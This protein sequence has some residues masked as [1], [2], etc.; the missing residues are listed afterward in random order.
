M[1][2][3]FDVFYE[4]LY[5]CEE[6]PE[7]WTGSKPLQVSLFGIPLDSKD[8]VIWVLGAP[9]EF[10]SQTVTGRFKRNAGSLVGRFESFAPRRINVVPRIFNNHSF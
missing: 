9:R 10:V 2:H 8:V 7:F 3:L 1:T 6:G 4:S 5:N